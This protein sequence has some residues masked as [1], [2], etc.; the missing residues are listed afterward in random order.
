MSSNVHTTKFCLLTT[1]RSGS[2]WLNELLGSH[3]ELKIF[4]GEIFLDRPYNRNTNTGW[5]GDSNFIPFYDY[6][7]K[8]SVI[9]P[10][11]TFNYLDKID[12]YPGSYNSIGF[13]LMYNQLSR[14]P[15]I[16]LKLIFDGYKVI[17]LERKNYLDTII[18]MA[19]MNRRNIVHS[20]K[21]LDVSPIH[22]NV[23]KLWKD[24]QWQDKKIGFIK[25]ILRLFPI[26]VLHVSYESLRCD[27]DTQLDKIMRFL[28]VSN[29]DIHL[30]TNLQKLS[31]DSY[32]E[33][34]ENYN[35]V[36]QKLLGTKYEKFI[37]G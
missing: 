23:D 25:N 20:R 12:L 16:L 1:Q 36:Y 7:L 17:H 35:Q 29:S 13:N 32:S 21:N 28:N 8:N 2:T 31:L 5:T 34:I 11:I 10:W 9:R 14:Y 33:K 15:E 6:Q 26:N 3:P 18:S 27:Q 37:T 19:N 4:P 30:Q 24:L 22:L